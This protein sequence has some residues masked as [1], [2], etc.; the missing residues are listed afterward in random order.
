MPGERAEP[1]FDL[2][3][4]VD[5]NELLPWTKGDSDSHNLGHVQVAETIPIPTG[6]NMTNE[7]IAM[8]IGAATTG[9]SAP[10]AVTT[11]AA[12]SG[13]V[14]LV[15]VA[16]VAVAVIGVLAFLMTRSKRAVV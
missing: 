3:V 9:D 6:S 16:V 1:G 14:S 7:L 10:P 4:N 5:W 2:L 13:S 8:G 15:I 11:E 12:S